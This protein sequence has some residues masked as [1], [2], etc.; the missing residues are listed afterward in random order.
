[1]TNVRYNFI[2]GLTSKVALTESKAQNVAAIFILF[3]H[4]ALEMLNEHNSLSKDIIIALEARS[5]SAFERLSEHS[6][7][8]ERSELSEQVSGI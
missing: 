1:M 6:T 7:R 8:S 5:W 3:S 4:F 2:S